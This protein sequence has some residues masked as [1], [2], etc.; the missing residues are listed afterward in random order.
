MVRDCLIMKTLKDINWNQVYCFYEVA[1]KLSM[2][3]AGQL[4][5]VST[6][7]VSEQI[8]RL[9]DL[10][11]ITL[12]HRYPRRIELTDDGAALFVSAK[13]IFDAGGRFLD[14]VSTDP[15][16][17]YAVRVGIQ[18]TINAGVGI[19]FVN[20]Y[21][22]L[23]APFGTVNT[24]RELMP[25]GLF[26][27][28]IRGRYDWGISCELPQSPRL[29]SRVVSEAELVFCCSPRILDKFKHKEDILRS[30]P[31]ARSTWDT[32]FNSLIDDAFR[33]AGIFPDEIIESD[34][35]QF[36]IGLA[37]RG[38]CVATFPKE[39]VETSS[40]GSSVATFTL[41]KPITAKI[42]AIWPSGCEKM[43]SIKK[44]L[45]LLDLPEK[46]KIME[47][48]DLQIRVGEVADSMLE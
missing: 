11:G 31:I 8:K 35:H 30:I 2:K 10:I 28:L 42:Y 19:E 22:D 37:Q 7:T 20:Q 41:D 45:E 47:D 27:N 16:G 17:G 48:P 39:T 3:E 26:T 46:P 13:E 18:E 23:F 44:L 4:L 15:I 21:W 32:D 36:I 34:H 24:V 25:E 5:G 38:R 9:E 6:P 1:R 29:K 40:W 14:T 43:I 12:F 33:E